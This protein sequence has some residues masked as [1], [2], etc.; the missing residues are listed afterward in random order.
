MALTSRMFDEAREAPAAV[1]RLMA[2]DLAAYTSLGE[3]L[4][5]DPPRSALTVARG[6]SDHAAH[7]MAYLVMARLGRLGAFS[8]WGQSPDLI[9]PIRFRRAGGART[10]AVVNDAGS[11]LAE[12]AEWVLPLHA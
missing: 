6:S 3:R 8:Q 7:Y 5:A 12:A 2:A 4:R 11:P 1:A 9:A 10:V